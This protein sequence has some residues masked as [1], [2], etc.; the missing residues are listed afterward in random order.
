MGD[1]HRQIR[2]C[3]FHFLHFHAVFIKIWWNN[4]LA[5][6]SEVGAPSGKSWICPLVYVYYKQRLFNFINQR[7]IVDLHRFTRHGGESVSASSTLF[8]HSWWRIRVCIQYTVSTLMVENPCRRQGHCFN[9]HGGESVSASST[10]FQHSW[11]RIRVC[12]QYTVSTLMV[13]NPCRHPVHCFN[14]HCGES[15]SAWRTLFHPIIHQNLPV[16]CRHLFVD[17]IIAVISD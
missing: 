17:I 12:I 3:R 8:Q 2:P 9:R 6:P 7:K 1:P 4:G 16:F 14:R 10:L 13:E 11:W 5:L 15:V